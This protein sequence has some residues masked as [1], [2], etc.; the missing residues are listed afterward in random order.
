MLGFGDPTFDRAAPAAGKGPERERVA[1]AGVRGVSAYFRGSLADPDALSGLTPLHDTAD[2]LRQITKH[3]GVPQSEI[4][5]G[6]EASETT[7]ARLS[8]GGR[9]AAYRVVHFATH[10]LVPATSRG[11]PSRRWH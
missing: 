1:S 4:V 11:W 6:P 7:V 9:L 5:L 8:E 10:G 2:E 3:L